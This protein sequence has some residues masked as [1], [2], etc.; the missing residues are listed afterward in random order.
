ML[1]LHVKFSKTDGCTKRQMYKYAYR[2]TQKKKH[3]DRAE[4]QEC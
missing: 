1:N 4:V 3:Y 2:H